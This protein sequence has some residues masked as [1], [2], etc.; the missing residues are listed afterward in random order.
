MARRKNIIIRER[1]QTNI[2]K[3]LLDYI[4]DKS[5]RE[6]VGVNY[7]LEQLIEDNFKNCQK[8]DNE[9]NDDIITL[10]GDEDEMPF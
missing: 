6:G 7:L 3:D 1:F 8:F 2:R 10:D 5:A 9:K 4:K